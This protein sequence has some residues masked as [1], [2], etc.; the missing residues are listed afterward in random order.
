MNKKG[1]ITVIVIIVIILVGWLAF[2]GSGSPSTPDT[3]SSSAPSTTTEIP[4]GVSKDDYKPVTK[5]TTDTSLLGRLKNSSVGV[6]EDGTKVNLVNGSATFTAAGSSVSSKAVVGDIAIEKAEGS[7]KDV[8]SSVSVTTGNSNTVYL[9]L[10]QDNGGSTL[11][12]KSYAIL[13]NKVTVTGIRA[14]DVADSNID[15]VVSVTYTDANKAAHSKIF[16]VE[17][18][19]F[20]L[21]KTIEL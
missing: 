21:A 18:G 17:G 20:N 5:D 1:I 10:F 19:A 7:R 9:V 4:A 13:G 6:T 12:D 16:V 15:Y 14:D 3:G 8:L 11:S 2:R